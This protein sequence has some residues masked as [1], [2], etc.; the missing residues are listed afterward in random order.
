MKNHS[1]LLVQDRKWGYLFISPMVIGNIL[2]LTAPIVVAF[3]LSLTDWTIMKDWKFIGLSNYIQAFNEDPLFWKTVF[4]TL[5]FT[6]VFVPLNIVLT[7]SLALLLKEP[8]KGVGFFRTAMFTP[9]VTSVIVWAVVWQYILQTENGLINAVLELFGITGPAWLYDLK[10][11]MPVIVI[12]TLLKGFGINMVIF[13]AAL[14]DVP[15]M[16]YEAAKLDGAGRWSMFRNVTLP[17]IAPSLFMVVI[18]T[19]IASLKVFG[20][21]YILTQGGPNM[22]TYV[23]VYYIYVKAFRMFEFGYASAISFILFLII[24]GLTLAQ[25]SLRKRWVHYE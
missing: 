17:L 10:L 5:Y 13:L 24:L 11:A 7:L 14:N 1:K 19:M 8:I 6:V 9:V 15:T 20:Q 25:W 21:I 4:N 2:F 22:S 3:F 18:L 12:V 16:Y 23:F